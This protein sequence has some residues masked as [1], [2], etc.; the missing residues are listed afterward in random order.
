M[1][2][3]TLKLKVGHH[4][5]H[6]PLRVLFD[7]WHADGCQ[8]YAFS[9]S[10]LARIHD[11]FETFRDLLGPPP[12]TEAAPCPFSPSTEA[13]PLP[14][15]EAGPL[16]P[17][18]EVQLDVYTDDDFPEIHADLRAWSYYEELL[19]ATEQLHQHLAS[20]A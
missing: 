18:T 20:D 9:K 8:V 16:P 2:L 19:Q 7:Q 17:F 10:Q 15:P 4:Y 6:L 11:Q 14:F 13:G 5:Q 3:P 12:S 1:A